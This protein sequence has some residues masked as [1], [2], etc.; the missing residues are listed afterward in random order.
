MKILITK[1]FYKASEIAQDKLDVFYAMNRLSDDEY[2]ELTQLVLM[3]YE[4]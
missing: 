3:I 1:K 4:E 2:K